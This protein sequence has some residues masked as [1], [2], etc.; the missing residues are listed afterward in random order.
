[1]TPPDCEQWA[2]DVFAKLH[3]HE[4]HELDRQKFYKYIRTL[5]QKLSDKD[6]R[7]LLTET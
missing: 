4:A 3:P 7:E 6:I 2:F 5:C 1:M